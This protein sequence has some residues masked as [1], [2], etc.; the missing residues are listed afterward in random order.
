M[1]RLVWGFMSYQ[2]MWFKSAA[3]QLQLLDR[4][5]SFETIREIVKIHLPL[6]VQEMELKGLDSEDPNSWKELIFIDGVIKIENA[7]G[8][9]QRVAICLMDDWRTATKTLKVVRSRRF[10]MIR[11]D[12]GIDQHWILFSDN[13]QA[14]SN[15]YWMDVLYGQID[16]EPSGS[17][18]ALIEM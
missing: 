10:Q 11:T 2:A 3:S 6:A 18:C 9:L 15:D 7:E 8:K 1:C 17:G 14:Y 5:L 13:K 16:R 12:L 4:S